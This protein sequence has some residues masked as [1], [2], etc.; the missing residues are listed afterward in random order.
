MSVEA[1]FS[2]TGGSVAEARDQAAQRRSL[3]KAIT[4]T[5]APNSRLARST[6]GHGNVA[7]SSTSFDRA[8]PWKMGS[9]ELTHSGGDLSQDLRRRSASSPAPV[10]ARNV[11]MR[12]V[13]DESIAIRSVVRLCELDQVTLLGI[14]LAHYREDWRANSQTE[15]FRGLRVG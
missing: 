9:Y 13:D 5:T 15:M 1:G 4:P 12:K 10:L 14:V 7:C 11:D 8:S 3:P 2:F 6:S